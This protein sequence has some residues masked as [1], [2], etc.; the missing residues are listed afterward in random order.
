MHMHVCGVCACARARARV[1]VMARVDIRQ[2]AG[3]GSVDAGTKT[4][5]LMSEL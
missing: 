4:C 2:L 1:Q 5:M 3:V